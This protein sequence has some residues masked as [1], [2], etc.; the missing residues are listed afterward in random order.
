LSAK[1]TFSNWLTT[2]YLLIVRNEENF[3]EKHTYSFNYARLILIGIMVFLIAVVVS[4]F[5]VRSVLEQWL[6]PRY[7]QRE[8]KRQLIEMRLGMDSLQYQ[9]TSRDMYIRNLQII[10]SG[11]FT[12]EQMDSMTSPDLRPDIV[13]DER[14]EPV[15]SLFRT[16]FESSEVSEV[17]FENRTFS[18][19]FRSLYLFSPLDGVLSDSYNPKRDHYG[20][21]LVS[22]ENEPVKSVADGIVIFS[23][24]T[25]D[26]GHVIGIQHRAGLVSVYKHNSELLKNVGSFVTGGEIIAIVGN[27]GELT[28]G[29]HL[30]FE[31]WHNGNPVNPEEYIGF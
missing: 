1:K 17:S 2:R 23:S 21:D 15:D 4:I 14:L 22:K 6:D 3:A 28:S 31:L 13:L 8:A 25:L 19:E 26:G 9:L 11:G 20:I 7:T 24:W 5:L 10:L 16:Q 12:T 30:H 27:S 18:N 29:P